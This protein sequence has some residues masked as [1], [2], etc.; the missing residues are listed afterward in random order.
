V[1]SL[2]GKNEGDPQGILPI[3]EKPRLRDE[4]LA[5]FRRVRDEIRSFVQSLPELLEKEIPHA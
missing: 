5:V 3:R 4:V 1:S 2:S